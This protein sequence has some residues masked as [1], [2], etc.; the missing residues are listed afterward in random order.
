VRRKIK[1][2]RAVPPRIVEEERVYPP[3]MSNAHDVFDTGSVIA[4]EASSGPIDPAE[5]STLEV[6]S[7]SPQTAASLRH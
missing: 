1:F 7:T 5:D 3:L 4:D 2:G 6:R